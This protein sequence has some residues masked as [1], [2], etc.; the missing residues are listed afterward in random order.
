MLNN[1]LLLF[2]LY[3][4]KMKCLSQALRRQI[5]LH[6]CL[7]QSTFL[8]LIGV[9]IA[10][11]YSGRVRAAPFLQRLRQVGREGEGAELFLIWTLP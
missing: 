2:G 10:M 4:L 11:I 3:F 5:V 6:D 1:L 7:E 9:F 8:V